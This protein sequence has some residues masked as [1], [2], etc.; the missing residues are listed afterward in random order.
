MASD[1]IT[2]LRRAASPTLRGWMLDNAG[3]LESLHY[4]VARACADPLGSF[5]YDSDGRRYPVTYVVVAAGLDGRTGVVPSHD[6]KHFGWTPNYPEGFQTRDLGALEETQKIRTIARTLDPYR[7]LGRHMDPTLGPPVVWPGRDGRYYVLGGNG[8]TLAF[9]LTDDDRYA[10]YVAEGRKRWAEC[11]P[12][13][14]APAGTRWLLVRVVHGLNQ[15]QAIKLAAASQLSTSATEGRI[16]RALGLVRSLGLDAD[17]LPLPR[18]T[19][20]LAVDEIPD[21]E[22][23]SDQNWAFVNAVLSQMDNAKRVRYE[24][25]PEQKEELL[26]AVMIGLMPPALRKGNLLDDPKI[27]AAL[28]G[29]MPAV[30][31][32]HG[33]AQTNEI[34][35]DFDLYPVLDDAILVFDSLRRKRLSFKALRVLLD[36]ERKTARI[37]GTRRVSDASDLAIAFAGLLFNASRRSAPEEVVTKILT[38]YVEEANQFG[39]PRQMFGFGLSREKPDPALILSNLIPGFELPT[40]QTGLL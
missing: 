1:P 15:A 28:I 13:R 22:A 31:T 37:P 33:L 11:F 16:G 35:P 9:L 29:S 3:A 8:R 36:D 32:T 12:T 5:V 10:A 34:Y 4:R 30:L 18:W 14:A 27:E 6:P 21:F 39:A 23:A 2:T 19:K 26:T 7:L 24:N 25:D 20:A 38:K 17:R 40:R